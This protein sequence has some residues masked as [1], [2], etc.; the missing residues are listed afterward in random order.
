M[1]GGSLQTAPRASTEASSIPC[2]PST[3]QEI[4]EGKGREKPGKEQREAQRELYREG[5]ER[6]VQSVQTRDE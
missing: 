6:A 5:A 2:P 4:A 3:P 1:P